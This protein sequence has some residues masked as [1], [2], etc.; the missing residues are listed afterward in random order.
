MIEPPGDA[1]A[2]RRG[3]Q[4]PQ[5]ERGQGA[6]GP[7]IDPLAKGGVELSDVDQGDAGGGQGEASVAEMEDPGCS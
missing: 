6:E 7:E 1:A 2:D 3:Q 5:Q 4:A